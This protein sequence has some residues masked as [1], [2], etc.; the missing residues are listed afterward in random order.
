LGQVLL[1]TITLRHTTLGRTP[2]DESSA[3][4]RGLYLTTRNT[5]KR[6]ITMLST[7]FKPPV[8]SSEQPQNDAVERAATGIGC[9]RVLLRIFKEGA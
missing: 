5:D 1:S 7:G 3:R 8:P 6:Q 9:I 2:L 4:H